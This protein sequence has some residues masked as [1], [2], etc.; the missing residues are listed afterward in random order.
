MVKEKPHSKLIREGANLVFTCKLSLADA[1]TDCSVDV[2]T[3]DGRVLCIPCP[4]VIAPGYEKAVPNE[5]MPISKKPGTR[6][7]LVIRFTIVFPEY[8]SE[9]KKVQLRKLLS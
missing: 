3:L 8:V 9:D 6:G 5:G 1:I 7:D 4:E 2:P